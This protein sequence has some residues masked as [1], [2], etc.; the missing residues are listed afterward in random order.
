MVPVM[1]DDVETVNKIEAL[2]ESLQKVRAKL[3]I[4]HH[5]MTI[6]VVF[7]ISL[8]S[9]LFA[10]VGACIVLGLTIHF[11]NGYVLILPDAFPHLYKA[12]P[13]WLGR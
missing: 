11:T 10:L 13:T 4:W 6:T 2:K 5:K 1:E 8:S 7:G 3:D 12:M 9:F